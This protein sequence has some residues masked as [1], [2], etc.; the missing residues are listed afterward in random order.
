MIQ[1]FILIGILIVL[2]IQLGIIN[3]RAITRYFKLQTV[4]DEYMSDDEED[5]IPK[6]SRKRQRR[7]TPLKNTNPRDDDNASITS[8]DSIIS[9]TPMRGG[10]SRGRNG[11]GEEPL[12]TPLNNLPTT[13]GSIRGSNILQQTDIPWEHKTSSPDASDPEAI[14]RQIMEELEAS[15]YSGGNGG[16]PRGSGPSQLTSMSI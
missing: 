16:D 1:V 13:A 8:D 3:V 9:E 6:K 5:Y 14:Q 10:Q 11:N 2:C 7:V 4:S 12:M 15:H